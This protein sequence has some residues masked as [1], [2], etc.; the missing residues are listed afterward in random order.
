MQSGNAGSTIQK[1]TEETKP[2]IPAPAV[3]SSA[4]EPTA[5]PASVKF[6]MVKMQTS[7]VPGHTI[8]RADRPK[9]LRVYFEEVKTSEITVSD[10][11]TKKVTLKIIKYFFLFISSGQ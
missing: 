2:T 11:T 4:P 10:L 6:N 3:T 1:S 9:I 5:P 8:K 7:V